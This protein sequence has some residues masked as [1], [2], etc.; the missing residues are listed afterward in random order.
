MARARGV[1]ILDDPTRLRRSIKRE[2]QLKKKKASA[3]AGRLDEQRE[4]REAKQKRSV[5][6]RVILPAVSFGCVIHQLV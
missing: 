5:R 6:P 3:W 4:A 1:R 2:K